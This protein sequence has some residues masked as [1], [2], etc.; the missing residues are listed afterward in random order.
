MPSIRVKDSF[1]DE[2]RTVSF[3]DLVLPLYRMADNGMPIKLEGTCFP[4]GRGIYLGS[5]EK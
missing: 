3:F 1:I 2:E 5:A 4:I